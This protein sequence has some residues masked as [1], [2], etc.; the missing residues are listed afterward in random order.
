MSVWKSH[1]AVSLIWPLHHAKYQRDRQNTFQGQENSI[2][3]TRLS[4]LI[5][6]IWL[7][8]WI[9]FGYD[10]YSMI[11]NHFNITVGKLLKVQSHVLKIRLILTKPLS[12]Y[13]PTNACQL[14]VSSK[15][16]WGK[17]LWIRSWKDSNLNAEE[18]WVLQQRCQIKCSCEYQPLINPS[19]IKHSLFSG[20]HFLSVIF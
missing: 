14:S 1:D 17:Q 6:L 11:Q 20:W 19:A 7:L 8:V 13:G 12:M 5:S 10:S 4:S 18:I 9:I 3:C 15:P 2:A 16:R